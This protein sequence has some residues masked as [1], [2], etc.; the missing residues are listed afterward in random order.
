MVDIN[1]ISYRIA[2]QVAFELVDLLSQDNVQANKL[3]VTTVELLG[4]GYETWAPRKYN[5]KDISRSQIW[6]V[7]KYSPC[8]Y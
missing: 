5:T 7:L 6:S 2:A 4:K 3:N 1:H 8:L